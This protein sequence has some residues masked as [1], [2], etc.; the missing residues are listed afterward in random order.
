MNWAQPQLL[1]RGIFFGSMA[2]LA[3]GAVG[4]TAQFVWRARAEVIA[5]KFDAATQH[6]RAFED[7]LTQSFNVIS[8]TLANAAEIDPSRIA[9]PQP[10]KEFIAALRQ[11]PY[12]RSLALLDA[13]DTIVASSN[14][15]NLGR[16]VGQS[17]FVPRKPSAA[18]VIR[19]GPPWTGRDFGDGHPVVAEQ[20]GSADSASFLPVA[21]DVVLDDGSRVTLLAAVNSTS[22]KH[23]ETL[24]T[25]GMTFRANG[26]SDKLSDRRLDNTTENQQQT[27][28]VTRLS[29]A[30]DIATHSARDTLIEASRLNAQGA[31]D[32][33]AGNA[34]T[35]NT[36]GSLNTPATEGKITLAAVKD[37]DYLSI[38][39]KGNSLLWQSQ[40]GSGHNNETVK[41]ANISAGKGLSVNATGG[42]SIDL[43]AVAA[44]PE[45]ADSGHQ[46]SK[47]PPP[48][49]PT[50]S[51]L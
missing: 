33:S 21:R 46:D 38:A 5:S 48:P 12:L 27:A 7:H 50:H 49:P 43:P 30:G 2:V 47:I 51:L 40:N 17:D 45:A 24:S 9:A 31:I 15:H 19:V 6:A 10:P 22:S 34:A 8:L 16:K 41:L 25:D 28:Q 39:E 36:D 26:T 18:E 13:N 44:E 29:S 32:L 23:T 35:Y 3:L 42:I 37:S 4:L 20:A 14:V 11:A 1:R